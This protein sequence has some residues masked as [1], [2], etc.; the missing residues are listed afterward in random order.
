MNLSCNTIISVLEQ[1]YPALVYLCSAA[2]QMPHTYYALSELVS[3]NIGFTIQRTE[4]RL[5]YQKQHIQ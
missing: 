3:H 4:I 2:D 5:F 1:I